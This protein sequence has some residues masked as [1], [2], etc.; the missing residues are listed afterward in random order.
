MEVFKL[1][2][3]ENIE[4]MAYRK[5]SRMNYSNIISLI[6][7]YKEMKIIDSKNPLYKY[8]CY[9]TP[10]T[11]NFNK[12]KEDKNYLN[13]NQYYSSITDTMK[14]LK[15]I[16]ERTHNCT[17]IMEK[18]IN[19]NSKKNKNLQRYNNIIKRL[20]FLE[21]EKLSII[22]QKH[23]RSYLK[24]IAII[25][26]INKIIIGKFMKN[27]IKIQRAFKKIYLKREFKINYF[28]NLI[29]EERKNNIFKIQKIF[30]SYYI[31]VNKKKKLIIKGILD[32]RIKNIIFIQSI[33]RAHKIREKIN[34]LI[35]YRKNNYILTF[36]YK[37][38]NVEI[39]ILQNQ[40]KI[41]FFQTYNLEKCQIQNIFKLYI[42]FSELNPGN[43]YCQFLVDNKLFIDPRFPYFEAK[44]GQTFNQIEFLRG[45][46]IEGDNEYNC[47]KNIN[48]PEIKR[49]N[50]EYIQ[51][52]NENK[53]NNYNNKIN[54]STYIKQ[55]NSINNNNNNYNNNYNNNNTKKFYETY[56]IDYNSYTFNT[57]KSDLGNQKSSNYENYYNSGNKNIAPFTNNTSDNSNNNSRKQSTEDDYYTSLKKNL[58]GIVF[59]YVD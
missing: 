31:K 5:M 15:K 35:E 44:D 36:P 4:K 28:I 11:P 47:H 34:K 24:R 20:H 18:P 41:K 19:F 6:S 54:H 57:L 42:N 53:K 45:K 22:I 29:C 33:Y 2:G 7:L 59:E 55:N 16:K 9:Y 30:K 25:K 58:E 8:V 27:I 12:K 48:I 13:E 39:R 1:I 14:L 23:V 37:A 38:K 17:Q 49:N 32:N 56:N 50:M 10:Y 40:N 46:I 26:A 51:R 52:N 43:Y 3:H 21:Q